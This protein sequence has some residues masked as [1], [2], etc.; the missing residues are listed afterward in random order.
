MNDDS[1]VAGGQ[2]CL[3]EPVKLS[4]HSPVALVVT[5]WH[6]THLHTGLTKAG[7][8]PMSNVTGGQQMFMD[9]T[10]SD[11]KETPATVKLSPCTIS[12]LNRILFIALNCNKLLSDISSTQQVLM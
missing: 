8:R 12:F 10:G 7:P 3:R 2:M 1:D 6:I 9:E 4:M 11:I 5:V